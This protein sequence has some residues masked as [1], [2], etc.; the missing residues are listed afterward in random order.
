MSEKIPAAIEAF[1]ELIR[2][3][4]TKFVSIEKQLDKLDAKLD[5]FR[6]YNERTQMDLKNEINILRNSIQE[7]AIEPQVEEYTR[8]P[9]VEIKETLQNS[10]RAVPEQTTTSSGSKAQIESAFG[11]LKP[12]PLVEA[13]QEEELYQEDETSLFASSKK[14]QVKQEALKSYLEKLE[15]VILKTWPVAERHLKNKETEI[16][17]DKSLTVLHGIIEFIFVA[18]R[19]EFPDPKL[20]YYEKAKN[21]SGLGLFKDVSLLEKIET[22]Y[23]QLQSEEEVVLANTL[24]LGWGERISKIFEE[25][26]KRKKEAYE[27]LVYV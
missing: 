9:M 18:F 22:V 23:A 8:E 21:I 15:R 17:I 1:K 27:R 26:K 3:L 13:F 19:S 16:F 4:D 6:A 11:G 25:F 5:N 12:T 24:L 2:Q 10:Q 7:K 20:S 14:K